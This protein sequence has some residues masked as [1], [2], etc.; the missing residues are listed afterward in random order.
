LDVAFCA[1]RRVILEAFG[2]SR[3]AALEFAEEL[4]GAALIATR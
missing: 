2:R 4:S 1:M 3:H